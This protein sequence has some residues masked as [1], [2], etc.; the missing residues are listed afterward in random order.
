MGAMGDSWQNIGIDDALSDPVVISQDAGH[1]AIFYKSTGGAVK[2]TE[3]EGAWL[4]QP[5]SLGQPAEGKASYPID[6]ELAAISRNGDHS[7]VF[8]VDAIGQLWFRER[9]IW[10]ELDWSDTTWVKLLEG[11]EIAKPAVTSRHANHI[12]V[13]VKDSSGQPYYTRWSWQ[14]PQKL[15]LPLVGRPSTGAELVTLEGGTDQVSALEFFGP[16]GWSQPVALEAATFTSPLTLVP[17]GLDSMVLLGIKSDGYLYEAV[18][19]EDTNWGSWQANAGP[20]MN[21]GQTLAV[22][23]RRMNDIMV[24]GRYAAT[25]QVWYKHYTSLDKPLTQQEMSSSM[26]GLPRA[27]TL[28]FVDGKWI[29]VSLTRQA[30]GAWQVEARELSTGISTSLDLEHAN[31]GQAANRGAVAAA[32]LDIDGNSEVVVATLQSNQSDIDLSVLEFT[33]QD[34]ATLLISASTPYTWPDPLVGADVNVSIGDLNGDGLQNEVVV[35]Y[36]SSSAMHLGVFLYGE[37]GLVQQGASTTIN[38]PNWC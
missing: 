7:A 13:V 4:K 15:Y 21:V 8:G 20:G 10:N 25:D 16:P 27:Q 28:A 19:T 26:E 32:D 5:I 35:G 12:G 18:W 23:A 37:Y 9:T 14:V 2:F 11:V 24:L 6:S 30:G 17:R 3:W 29:W 34:P 31:S 36:S 22:V 38:Y 1:M 33:F